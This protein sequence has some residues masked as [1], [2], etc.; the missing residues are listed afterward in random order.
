[1]VSYDV[2][3]F[4]MIFFDFLCLPVV[5]Y[6]S[7]RFPMI[8]DV[9][10]LILLISYDFVWFP[11]NWEATFG[12]PRGHP[13]F[14]TKVPPR[15]PKSCA[16]SCAGHARPKFWSISGGGFFQ[17]KKI[18]ADIHP[19]NGTPEQCWNNQMHKVLLWFLVVSCNF[20]W[21][22]LISDDSLW[23]LIMSNDFLW[24]LGVSYDLLWFLRFPLISS[25]SSWFL[26]I[27][28]DFLWFP[29]IYFGFLRFPSISNDSSCFPLFS[30]DCRIYSL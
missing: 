5:S 24:F 30:H 13:S 18:L 11:L 16:K 19:R 7:L 8:F 23:F 25:D 15:P 1:M 10:S 9:F 14:V 2:L 12:G 3:R 28:C 21:L 6:D 20:L 22:Q 29:M 17:R 26:M 27:S 4:L